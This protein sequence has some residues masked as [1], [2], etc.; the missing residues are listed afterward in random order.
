MYWPAHSCGLLDFVPERERSSCQQRESCFSYLQNGPQSTHLYVHTQL[1]ICL[2]TK[3]PTKY[4]SNTE[5][6]LLYL[7]KKFW[8]N[9]LGDCNSPFLSSRKKETM[10]VN[11]YSFQTLSSYGRFRTIPPFLITLYFQ[12]QNDFWGGVQ[13]WHPK[14]HPRERQCKIYTNT[15]KKSS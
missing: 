13:I 12:L 7:S 6:G 9:K 3:W 5:I 15:H 11:I 14:S 8:Q 4:F 1:K 2:E 10:N